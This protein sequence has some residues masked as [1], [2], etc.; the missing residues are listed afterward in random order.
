MTRH[1]DEIT[2]T[3]TAHAL[4]LMTSL[5]PRHR[6]FDRLDVSE[7]DGQVFGRHEDLDAARYAGLASDETC[8]FEGEDHLVNGRWCHAEV[9]LD[10]GFG[11]GP[12]MDAGVGVDEGQI[13][14]LLGREAGS[15]PARHLIHLSIR[16]GLQPGGPDECTLS[17]R[18]DPIRAQR[19]WGASERGASTRRGSSSGHRSCWPRTPV[20]ATRTSPPASGSAGPRSTEPSGAL[21]RATWSGR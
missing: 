16:L 18:V 17:C 20:S 14:A 21:S 10:V 2:G 4:R 7:Q 13:L 11:R 8:T 12:P 5:V 1:K 3:T 19:A 15:V 9:S 6:G